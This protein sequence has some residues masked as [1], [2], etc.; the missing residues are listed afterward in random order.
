M[1]GGNSKV[2]KNLST[3]F[4]GRTF[5]ENASKYFEY[6]MRRR[7]FCRI[8]QVV[9]AIFIYG[10]LG[11][12]DQTLW[13]QHQM[14][15][16]KIWMWIF[17]ACAPVAAALGLIV[18][19]PHFLLF[20]GFKDSRA[21]LTAEIVI[22]GIYVIAHFAFFVA[23]LSMMNGNN[24]V[25]SCGPFVSASCDKFNWLV[26]FVVFSGIAWAVD[27]IWTIKELYGGIRGEDMDMAQ[28]RQSLRA[29]HY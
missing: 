10:F 1:N 25:A 23:L 14:D 15:A 12:Q 27:L 26:T 22:N 24:N 8:F 16:L 11:A 4:A 19:L 9:L 28:L 7:I 17:L 21:K 3:S 29:T 5:D 6:S 18:H 20:K 13:E 2:L